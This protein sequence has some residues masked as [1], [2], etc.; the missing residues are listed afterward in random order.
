[1]RG[2][3]ERRKKDVSANLHAGNSLELACPSA[4]RGLIRGVFKDKMD[5]S[6]RFCD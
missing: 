6:I 5:V 1:M 2:K 4:R 3:G